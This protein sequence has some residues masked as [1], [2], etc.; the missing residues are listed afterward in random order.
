VKVS[1]SREQ[2]QRRR[3]AGTF[4]PYLEAQPQ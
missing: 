1:L 2:G 4:Q 3:I